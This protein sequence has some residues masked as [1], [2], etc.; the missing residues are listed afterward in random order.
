MTACTDATIPVKNP[1]SR[2]IG[3]DPTPMNSI[4][5]RNSR[6][7]KGGRPSQAKASIPSR[8]CSP[9]ELSTPSTPGAW[10]SDSRCLQATRR[11]RG[12]GGGGT[13]AGLALTA[14]PRLPGWG[15]G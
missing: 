7:R 3:S 5:S 8:M 14:P 10:V 9:K 6:V 12:V 1:T 13:G 4:C 11:P 2:T 15:P